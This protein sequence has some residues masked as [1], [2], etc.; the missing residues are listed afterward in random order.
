MY[1]IQKNIMKKLIYLS[2]IL[3]SLNGFSQFGIG[4]GYGS[5]KAKV[6]EGSASIS[7]DAVSGLS[8]GLIAGIPISDAIKLETGLSFG[9]AK[10]DGESSKSWGIPLIAKFY[11][12]GSD[13]FHIRGGVGY[14]ATMEDVDTDVL[15]KGAFSAGLGLGYDISENFALTAT[16]SSQI[17]NSAGSYW[18]DDVKIK[19]SGFGVGLQYF[20]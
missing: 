12:N 3:F 17:S 5:S 8:L 1:I 2:F 10:V 11:T 18:N 19:G 4:I 15:K 6:S 20:F 7:G 13:G 14:S 16:Y 9:F